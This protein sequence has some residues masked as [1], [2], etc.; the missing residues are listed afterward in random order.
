MQKYMANTGMESSKTRLL[1]VFKKKDNRE[2]NS[3][4]IKECLRDCIL[5][6]LSNKPRHQSLYDISENL[7]NDFR[8]SEKDR[9]CMDGMRL[10]K[11]IFTKMTE[12]SAVD[13]RKEIVF[14]LQGEHMW[15]EWSKL[16]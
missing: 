10:A 1:S 8:S 4:E 2:L 12:S 7:S 13:N 16:E 14:P 3:F 11:N 15:Q 5:K 6:G 9:K